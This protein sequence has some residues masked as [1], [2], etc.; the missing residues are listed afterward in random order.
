MGDAIENTSKVCLNFI[1][2]K[3]HDRPPVLLKKIIAIAVIRFSHEMNRTV[4]LNS[5]KSIDA[6]K[7]QN[8]RTKW[9]LP[10]KMESVQPVTTK[11]LP[12]N[13]LRRCQSPP[14]I[15]G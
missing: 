2:R 14:K 3:T 1:V 4:E 15:A 7:V 6:S 5:E 13:C 8:V 11:P 12:E 9:M 10:A